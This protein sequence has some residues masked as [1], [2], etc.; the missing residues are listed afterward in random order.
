MG[1]ENLS[2]LE[3]FLKNIMRMGGAQQLQEIAIALGYSGI[4]W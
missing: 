2:E 3:K 1:Y 4:P